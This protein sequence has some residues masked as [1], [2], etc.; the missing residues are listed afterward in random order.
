M[1][2]DL[3]DFSR[4]PLPPCTL[5]TVGTDEVRTGRGGGGPSMES[6]VHSETG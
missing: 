6:I 1:H 3:A 5:A 2:V 4:C